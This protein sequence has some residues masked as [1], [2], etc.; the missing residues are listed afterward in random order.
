MTHFTE[1]ENIVVEPTRQRRQFNE[2]SGQDL[3]N[4]IQRTGLLH[5]LVVEE[6]PGGEL[7]LRAGERRLIAI[8]NIYDFGGTFCYSGASVEPGMVPYS[9]WQELTELQRLEIEV[10]ENNQREA[11][12]WQ[13]QAEVTAKLTRLRMMQAETDDAPL[14]TVADIALEIRGSNIGSAHTKTRDDL[15]LS[16]HLHDPEVRAAKSQKEAI[17][18]LKKKEQAKQHQRLAEI[19]G[20]EGTRG[21]LT[22]VHADSEVWCKAQPAEGFDV[23][24][25]DPP[26]GIGADGF[27]D[28]AGGLSAHGYADDED[29]LIHIMD[30]FGP[31]SFRLAKPKAHLY[32]FCDLSWFSHWVFVLS[33]AGWRVFSTPL[34]WVKP[35]G[36]RTP[37]IDLGPQRK[38]ECILYANKGDR[39][40]NMIASDV[41]IL[42][43]PGEGLGHS[44]AKPPALFEELLHR[45][46]RP[47]DSVLDPFC[48]TGPV[49]G[50][51]KALQ[52]RATGVEIDKTFYGTAL[53]QIEKLLAQGE[54][55][56]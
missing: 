42:Q 25:T 30:W 19:V 9:R 52:C 33:G 47:G 12:T 41:I 35:T 2:K 40:V 1:I 8:Q 26:Y 39:R 43:S 37:W 51:A 28:T 31:E 16:K 15:I 36:F 49:F 32:V 27:G 4:S 20:K 44:A 14:P 29:T 22:C 21:L 13:E 17:A 45:S 18:V 34:I 48:G 10:E 46:V 11:F 54:L 55:D 53:A 5:A 24:C 3:Q 23:I 50:A 6:K 38:Y 56:V 7:V